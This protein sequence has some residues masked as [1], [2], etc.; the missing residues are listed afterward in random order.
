MWFKSSS[1]IYY[2]SEDI[3]N[4]IVGYSREIISGDCYNI[5]F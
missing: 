2:I 4:K 3:N 5:Y 1:D